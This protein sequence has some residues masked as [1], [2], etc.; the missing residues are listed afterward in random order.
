MRPGV[1]SELHLEV[2]RSRAWLTISHG[3]TL[4][5]VQRVSALVEEHPIWTM[6]NSNTEEVVKRSKVLHHEGPL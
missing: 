4:D 2:D 3:C 6:L 1:C 5:D